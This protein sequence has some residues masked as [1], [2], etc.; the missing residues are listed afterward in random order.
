MW[1][2]I[3]GWLVASFIVAVIFGHAARRDE[4]TEERFVVANDRADRRPVLH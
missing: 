2:I 3:L 4:G 1:W